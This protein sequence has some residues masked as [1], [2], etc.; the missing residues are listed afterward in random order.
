MRYILVEWPESQKFMDVEEC[1][2]S[3]D[4][5]YFVPEDIYY[6]TT[7]FIHPFSK[8]VT[9]GELQ[10]ILS[11]YPKDATVAVEYCD[12]K[13]LKYFPDRNFIAID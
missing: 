5:S 13:N 9:N 12:V 4:G 2:L 7:G 8:T 10:D 1:I 11:Q 3:E 6:N